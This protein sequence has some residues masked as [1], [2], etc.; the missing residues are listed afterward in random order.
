MSNTYSVYVKTDESANII[1]VNSSK[2]L[3]DI[4][5]WIKIDEGTGEKH[6]YAQGNYFDLPFV[7]ISGIYRY[8]LVDGVAVEKTD[9]EIS[10]EEALIPSTVDGKATALSAIEK[11]TTIASLRTAMLN[12]IDVAGIG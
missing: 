2:F 4:S 8:K 11:A 12:Y 7:T 9:G 1:A 6:C 10:T 5:G 3:L